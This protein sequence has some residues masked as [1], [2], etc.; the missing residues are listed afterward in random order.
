MTK[1]TWEAINADGQAIAVYFCDTL[2]QAADKMKLEF[3]DNRYLLKLR[4]GKVRDLAESK[5]IYQWGGSSISLAMIDCRMDCIVMKRK[6]G[7]EWKF[8]LFDSPGAVRS[9]LESAKGW[10]DANCTGCPDMKTFMWR[11]AL[12]WI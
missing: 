9:F 1:Q 6:P 11:M 4:K 12:T 10:K 5:R 3:G 7:S 8:E 2:E